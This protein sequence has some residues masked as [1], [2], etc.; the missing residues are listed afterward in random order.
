MNLTLPTVSQ[1]PGP[2]W[3]NQI[4]SNLTVIDSHNHSP[5]N[6]ASIPSAALNINADVGFG[7]YSAVGLGSTQYV[8]QLASTAACAVYAF[9]GELYYNNSSAVPVQIT[10][11]GAVV[12]PSGNWTNLAPPAIAGYNVGTGTFSFQ[13][14]ALTFGTLQGASLKLQANTSSQP[15]TLTASAATT[16]YVLTLP[17]VAPAQVGSLLAS[18]NTGSM[19]W[20]TAGDSSI[21]ITSS[22]IS[23]AT[24]GISS[25]QLASS[26]V[27]TSKISDN[28]VTQAKL[29]TKS[30]SGTAASGVNIGPSHTVVFASFTCNLVAGRPAL[31]TLDA[32]QNT[33]TAPASVPPAASFSCNGAPSVYIAVTHPN[34]TTQTQMCHFVLPSGYSAPSSIH[35]LFDVISTGTH[36]IQ[37]ASYCGTIFDAVTLANGFIKAFQL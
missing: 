18:S 12:G 22:T 7:T 33:G 1:T 2:S 26:A 13:S 32:I 30:T 27:L 8:N 9:N 20:V 14:N 29:E 15:I 31:I 17:V 19:S 5:G 25:T 4:N 11:G 37:L 6:G 16:S 36:T 3:A 35:G 23:V 28:A 24:G 10:S 34:G 21:S